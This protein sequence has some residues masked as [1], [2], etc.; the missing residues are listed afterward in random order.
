MNRRSEAAPVTEPAGAREGAAAADGESVAA[1]AHPADA[2]WGSRVDA[3]R[4]LE[5]TAARRVGTVHPAEASAAS[6]IGV[7]VS[8]LRVLLPA[9]ILLFSV[10]AI[11]RQIFLV[12]QLGNALDLGAERLVLIT[13][14]TSFVVATPLLR[15]GRLLPVAIAD[16]LLTLFAIGDLVYYRAFGDLPSVASLRF[17]SQLPSVASAAAALVRPSDLVLLALGPVAF[18]G[19]R[20]A[21]GGRTR[22]SARAIGAWVGVGAILVAGVY[23]TTP[24]LGRLRHRGN[25]FLAGELGL[26]NFH[27]WEAASYV[28]KRA[29]RL[30]PDPAAE[31]AAR[32]RLSELATID[33]GRSELWGAA[34]GRSVIV[35]QLESF[36]SFAVGLRIGGQRVTPNLDALAGESMKFT[37]FHHQTAGGRTSDAQFV[38]SCSLHPSR[39]GAAVF[40][41]AGD[42]LRCLPG[43]LAGA[44]Y[45]TIAMQTMGA[46][47]WNAAAIEPKLG[48]QRSLKDRDF[49]QDEVIGYGLSDRSFFRQ[50]VEVLGETPE[51]F[52]A[53]IVGLTSHAPFDWPNLPRVLDLGELE[54]TYLG[55]YLHAVH[56]TDR[57]VG[58]LVSSLRERG[59]LD[60]AVLVIFGDHDGVTRRSAQGLV[61]VLGIRADDEL[62]WTRVERGIPLLVRLPGGEGAGERDALGGQIDLAPTLVGLLGLPREGTVFLGNNL[63]GPPAPAPMVAFVDGSALGISRLHS[64]GACHGEEGREPAAE[65]TSL[66]RAAARDLAISAGILEGD[67]SSKLS[68]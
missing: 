43:L 68:R 2:T 60:R 26:F 31:R 41:Y 44:G 39:T 7:A 63:L 61:D 15:R 52:Y 5:T 3:A 29:S 66:E 14:G 18:W 45:A 57:A 40:E 37:N 62:A 20:L 1:A 48:F 8:R 19:L 34:R 30:V 12:D 33:D 36:Q 11:L 65:C 55:N 58:E 42:E 4:S 17:A 35:L 9:P 23:A 54:G 46:D 53:S 16:S 47:Y 51:P 67:L 21:G 64:A 59:L 49:V 25:A 32:E 56:Y 24:R 6:R 38:A 10:L 28:A 13:L 50:A 27:L 22:L